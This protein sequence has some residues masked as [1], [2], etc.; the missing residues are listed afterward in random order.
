MMSEMKIYLMDDQLRRRTPL[1]VEQSAGR[2]GCLSLHVKT[3][4]HF[5]RRVHIKPLHISIQMASA[6]ILFHSKT[7]TCAF[8]FLVVILRFSTLKFST[9][10][11]PFERRSEI[12]TEC[13]AKP[14]FDTTQDFEIL[15]FGKSF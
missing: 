11:S 15:S 3:V 14:R 13:K 5:I 1:K 10:F 12:S 2:V 9:R 7:S 6:I 4:E 8:L